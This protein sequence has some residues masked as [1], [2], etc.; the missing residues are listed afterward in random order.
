MKRL[1][2]DSKVSVYLPGPFTYLITVFPVLYKSS[3]NRVPP[4]PPT[5]L[6]VP[7]VVLS[8]IDT[9]QGRTHVIYLQLF[10]SSQNTRAVDPLVANYFRWN[11]F[12]WYIIFHMYRMFNIH[13]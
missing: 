11:I 7:V 13:D 1:K 5:P 9:P 2:L 10:S 4:T 3:L 12:S 8:P 6:S